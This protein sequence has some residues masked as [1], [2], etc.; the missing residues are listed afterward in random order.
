MYKK[1]KGSVQ[2]APNNVIRVHA[3][4]HPTSLYPLPPPNPFCLHLQLASVVA[5]FSD[6]LSPKKWQRGKDDSTH[7]VRSY[8]L[9]AW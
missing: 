6:R 7:R 3:S 9:A 4:P 5:S 8:Q 1:F 2:R